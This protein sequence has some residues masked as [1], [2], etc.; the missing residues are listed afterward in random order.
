MKN[1]VFQIFDSCGA[2]WG[3]IRGHDPPQ[4]GFVQHFQDLSLNIGDAEQD[5]V[6]P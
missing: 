1:Y 6:G 5:T 4:N 2:F 3:G